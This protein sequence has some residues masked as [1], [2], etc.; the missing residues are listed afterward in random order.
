MSVVREPI[1]D[2]EWYRAVPISFAANERLDL[3][4]LPE[5]VSVPCEPF[6]KDY[7]LLSPPSEWKE[8]FDLRNWRAYHVVDGGL[9]LGSAVVAA[10]TPGVD[11]LEGRDDLGVLWDLRVVPEHRG[12]GVG[13]SLFRA[14]EEDLRADGFGH[15][16][17]ETQDINV[18]ACRFYCAMGC[19]LVM[20][21]PNAYEGLDEVQLIWQKAL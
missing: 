1:G 21:N 4:R 11:M 16:K 3:G 20:I 9:R 6:L 5:L 12:R 19:S 17:V 8:Q 14:V 13:R 18:R 2:L 10:R 7:D 15:L